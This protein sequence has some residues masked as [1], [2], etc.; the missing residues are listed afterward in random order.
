MGANMLSHRGGTQYVDVAPHDSVMSPTLSSSFVRKRPRNIQWFVALTKQCEPPLVVAR[1]ARK[2]NIDAHALMCAAL[3][4]SLSLAP[5]L[6][7]S[8]ALIS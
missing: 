1:C 5:V 2:S 6:S 8:S 3:H 4:L 7:V